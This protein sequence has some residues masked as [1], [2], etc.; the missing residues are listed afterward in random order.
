A[1]LTQANV[2]LQVDETSYD[3]L[4]GAAIEGLELNHATEEDWDTEYLALKMGIK[5]VPSLESAIDHI[6]IHSTGHTE[7]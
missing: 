6:N 2:V 5:V 7:S 4:E 3:I 1:A